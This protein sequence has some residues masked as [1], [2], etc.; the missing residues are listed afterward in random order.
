MKRDCKTKGSYGNT[1]FFSLEKDVYNEIHG[2]MIDLLYDL[3][4]NENYLKEKIDISF[5][6]VE[7]LYIPLFVDF[8]I[9]DIFVGNNLVYL[10]FHF[11]DEN[12]KRK[13]IQV[14]RKYFNY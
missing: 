6:S 12:Y 3:G 9:I 14:I 7:D 5:E 4:F 13:Y 10:V 2:T 11:K 8:G 1:L